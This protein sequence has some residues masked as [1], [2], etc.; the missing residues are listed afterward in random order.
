MNKYGCR[1]MFAAC[2]CLTVTACGPTEKTAA[3]DPGPPQIDADD[4]ASW[5][6]RTIDA[7]RRSVSA[8]THGVIKMVGLVKESPSSGGASEIL[9]VESLQRSVNEALASAHGLTEHLLSVRRELRH[10]TTVYTAAAESFRQRAEDYKDGRLRADC[11]SWARNFDELVATTPQQ[12]SDTENYLAEVGP[13]IEFIRETKNLLTDYHLFLSTAVDH[14]R[15]L[16]G[17]SSYL[18]RLKGYVEKFSR[19]EEAAQAFEKW[20]GGESPR[21]PRQPEPETEEETPTPKPA[22]R[23]ASFGVERA[24]SRWDGVELPEDAVRRKTAEAVARSGELSSPFPENH[25][26]ESPIEMFLQQDPPPA[27]TTAEHKETL[28]RLMEQDAP[29]VVAGYRAQALRL[30]Q[31][32]RPMVADDP[33]MTAQSKDG[34]TGRLAELERMLLDRPKVSAVGVATE[35]LGLLAWFE[36]TA[37]QRREAAGRPVGP[38]RDSPPKLSQVRGFNPSF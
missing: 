22:V 18:S 34:W 11:L 4:A 12:L 37:P 21:P 24:P 25:P 19:F 23:T 1:I 8:A 6:S 5:Q 32:L 26:R 29:H 7:S 35:L 2:A 15:T 31:Q 20:S 17:A 30:V 36:A 14:G 16:E 27:T 28:R 33:L 10:S 3:P 9:R 38:V 13:T